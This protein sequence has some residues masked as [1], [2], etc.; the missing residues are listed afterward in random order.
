[1]NNNNK[2]KIIKNI[3]KEFVNKSRSVNCVFDLVV[4]HIFDDSSFKSASKLSLEFAQC[5][6]TR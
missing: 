3:S 5:I 4:V 6:S 1:M 2:K